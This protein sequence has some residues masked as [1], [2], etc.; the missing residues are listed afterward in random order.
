MF[1]NHPVKKRKRDYLLPRDHLA[2]PPP[3]KNSRSDVSDKM[4][5]GQHTSNQGEHRTRYDSSKM[6]QQQ[7]QVDRRRGP[8]STAALDLS[9]RLK[10]LSRE[11][12]WDE[13]LQMYRDTSHDRIRDGHHACIMVDLA[14]RC[15]KISVS[16]IRKRRGHLRLRSAAIR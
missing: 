8:P 6:H 1:R 16:S 13:A 3:R 15:G 2:S 10:Q 7:Q 4:S 9:S 5:K 11:K 12:K 14:A